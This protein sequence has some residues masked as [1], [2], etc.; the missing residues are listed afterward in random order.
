MQAICGGVVAAVLASGGL[1][2]AGDFRVHNKVFIDDQPEPVSETVTLFFGGR[3]YDL[4]HDDSEVVVFDPPNKR[5]VLLQP[6]RQIRAEISL[7]QIEALH[8]RLAEKLREQGD[9]LSAFV[10]DPRFEQSK[11]EEEGVTTFRGQWM[12]YDVRTTPLKDA[13]Q[14]AASAEFAVWS[15]RLNAIKNPSLLA[16]RP[17][18]E[19]LAAENRF[20]ERVHLVRYQRNLFGGMTQEAE[21]K[22]QHTL[23]PQLS[24]GDRERI[25]QVD[26][27]LVDFRQTTL[28]EY[29]EA[30]REE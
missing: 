28:G 10:L 22:S 3:V 25:D 4:L 17:I 11:G 9:K 6:A 14:A 5:F 2:L 1:A 21:F 13:E 29:W 24:R 19:W 30:S 7:E 16:R 18:N 20:A 12:T 8:E 26:R 15:T 23:T 27:W